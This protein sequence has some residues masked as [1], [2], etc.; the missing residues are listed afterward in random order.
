MQLAEKLDW[1]GLNPTHKWT[2]TISIFGVQ[3]RS[4]VYEIVFWIGVNMTSHCCVTGGEKQTFRPS[5]M[6]HQ[7]D[8]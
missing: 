2:H 4:A 5:G 1:K 6:L 3:K 8:S 7:V